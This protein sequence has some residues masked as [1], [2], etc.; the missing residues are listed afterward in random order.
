MLGRLR[1]CWFILCEIKVMFVKIMKLGWA[2][3]ALQHSICA[4]IDV[5]ENLV[6]NYSRRALEGSPYILVIIEATSEIKSNLSDTP[7]VLQL[8]DKVYSLL[9]FRVKTKLNLPISP[10]FGLCN[11]T[12][13]S[14]GILVAHDKGTPNFAKAGGLW[15]QGFKGE[16]V[17]VYREPSATK[18]M[19]Y[20]RLS[21]RV[22]KI[23]TKF[24]NSHILLLIEILSIVKIF[25]W[26]IEINILGSLSIFFTII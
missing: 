14:I 3:A 7:W 8:L 17:V 18:E 2:A 10:G 4:W 9:E 12:F 20:H 5:S 1:P 11:K 19:G 25:K 22:N 23:D 16:A 26:L 21:R 24:Q 15:S 6:E 13:G